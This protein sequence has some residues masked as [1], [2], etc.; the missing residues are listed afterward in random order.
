[1]YPLSPF[2]LD[3]VV[4][5]SLLCSYIYALDHLSSVHCVV[6]AHVAICTYSSIP[7]SI[8]LKSVRKTE[9]SITVVWMFKVCITMLTLCLT[10]RNDINGT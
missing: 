10:N 6:R 5:L 9:E 1:M 4:L 7:Y 2:F 8:A 3:A